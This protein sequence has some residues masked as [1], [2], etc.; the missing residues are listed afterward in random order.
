M[1]NLAVNA[2][3]S[4]SYAIA[5]ER[6]KPEDACYQATLQKLCELRIFEQQRLVEDSVVRLHRINDEMSKELD[7]GHNA[8]KLQKR[9]HTRARAIEQAMSVRF[10]WLKLTDEAA[11]PANEA[12]MKAIFKGGWTL[13][14]QHIKQVLAGFM[15]SKWQMISC[16]CRCV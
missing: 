10:S 8:T 11:T 12:T 16:V 15:Y 13:H 4:E 9:K 6:W 14:L 2:Y 5:D 1:I 7:K 3:L